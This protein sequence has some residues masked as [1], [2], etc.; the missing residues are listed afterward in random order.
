MNAVHRYLWGRWWYPLLNKAKRKLSGIDEIYQKR[1]QSK[2]ETITIDQF[3]AENDDQAVALALAY[4]ASV[5]HG[6]TL[7]ITRD[8][9]LTRSISIPGTLTHF[10]FDGG[11]HTFHFPPGQGIGKVFDDSPW[12]R[13]VGPVKKPGGR[14]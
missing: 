6:V 14:G 10:H 13:L 12:W 8:L 5:E 3:P 2:R 11:G 1:A 4:A 7:L 9:W